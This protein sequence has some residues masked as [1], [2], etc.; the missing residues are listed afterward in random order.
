MGLRHDGRWW[1]FG[2]EGCKFLDD[3]GLDPSEEAQASRH[4]RGPLSPWL[5]VVACAA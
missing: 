3:F 4:R 2:R 5:R 1:V